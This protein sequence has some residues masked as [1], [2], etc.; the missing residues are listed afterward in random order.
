ML[1]EEANRVSQWKTSIED[2][3][4][5]S[6]STGPREVLK[7]G[8]WQ[9][10]LA[11]DTDGECWQGKMV[12]ENGCK[13]SLSFL[14][15]CRTVQPLNILILPRW[16]VPVAKL[17]Y[18]RS[19]VLLTEWDNPLREFCIFAKGIEHLPSAYFWPT[20]PYFVCGVRESSGAVELDSRFRLPGSKPA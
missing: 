10:V 8:Y 12:A 18:S 14:S 9:K 5:R 13:K 7:G 3:N 15:G 4:R 20:P 17:F 6:Q 1:T 11:E 19:G 16:N 2:A